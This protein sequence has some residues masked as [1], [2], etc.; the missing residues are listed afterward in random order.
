MLDH[1]LSGA[2][3][4]HIIYVDKDATCMGIMQPT[5]IVVNGIHMCPKS[6]SNRQTEVLEFEA[7]AFTNFAIGAKQNRIN[8]PAL[9][10]E[11]QSQ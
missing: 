3:P 7:S 8:L 11:L 6:D 1:K 9:P 2:V 10:T 4:K 5:G